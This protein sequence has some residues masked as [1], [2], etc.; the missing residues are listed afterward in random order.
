MRYLFRNHFGYKNHCPCGQEKRPKRFGRFFLCREAYCLGLKSRLVA[1][2]Y[3]D[4][5][6]FPRLPLCQTEP[7]RVFFGLDRAFLEW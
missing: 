5:E 2:V 3:I 4:H 6:P 1:L 7:Y